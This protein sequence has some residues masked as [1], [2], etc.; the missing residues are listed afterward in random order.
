MPTTARPMPAA[1]RNDRFEGERIG[2]TEPAGQRQP[3]HLQQARRNRKKRRRTRSAIEILVAAADREIDTIGRERSGTAPAE[4]DKSHS[5]SA[6]ASCAAAVIVAM[7]CI[8][9]V[10]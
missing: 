4:C 3:Q 7:S 2:V 10:R 8:A 1:G 9:P 6:P 5:T